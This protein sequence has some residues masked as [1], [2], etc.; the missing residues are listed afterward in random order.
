MRIRLT[1]WQSVL[2]GRVAHARQELREL[3]TTPIRL[4]PC[5]NARGYRALRF[6]GCWGLNAVFGAE[7]M[8]FLREG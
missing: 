2:T 4:T 8:F 1:E 6:D 3:L 5:V 7:V